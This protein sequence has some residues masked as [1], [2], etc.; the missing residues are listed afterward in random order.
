MI[1]PGLATRMIHRKLRRGGTFAQWLSGNSRS[2]HAAMSHV[3]AASRECAEFP[4][5][6]LPEG[7][8]KGAH[9]FRCNRLGFLPRYSD[10][11]PMR[12]N[13]PVRDLLHARNAVDDGSM[14][15]QRLLCAV[16]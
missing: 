16:W 6:Y 9:P 7:L 15:T 3:T 2:P 4:G 10:K 1:V 14:F 8:S 13:C 12:R 5:R 11:Q